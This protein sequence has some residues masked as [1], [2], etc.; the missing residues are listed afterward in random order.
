T[1]YQVA[2]AAHDRGWQLGI[3]TIGDAAA[4]MAVRQIERILRESPRDDHRHYLHH[5]NVK[6]PEET[7]RT[8]ARI[9]MMVATHPSWTTSLGAD[10]AETIG[11]GPKLQ[12]QTPGRSLLNHGIRISY[13]SDGLPYSPLFAISNAVTRRGWDGEV[14]GPEEAVTVEEAIR[15]HTMGT[16]YITFDE[17]V[18]GSVEV[19]KLADFVILGDDPLSVD[20]EA[21]ATIPVEATFIGGREVYRRARATA[22]R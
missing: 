13:G 15:F 4:V 10:A 18:K 12:T 11:P 5:I 6:P 8:M 22:S 14:Y 21:I 20:P 1:F 17:N 9:G 7:L 2:K 19:G 3:H 16:A